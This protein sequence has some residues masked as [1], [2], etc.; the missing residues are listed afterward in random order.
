V[1]QP[2]PF[3]AVLADLLEERDMSARQLS[4]LVG[5]NS[6]TSLYNILH[7]K[8]VPTIETTEAIARV[9]EVK[10]EVFAEFRLMKA[11]DALDWRRHGLAKAMRALDS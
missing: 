2:R 10:P 9:L 5:L 6:A 4:L 1:S 7:G 11:Q 8:S 3:A